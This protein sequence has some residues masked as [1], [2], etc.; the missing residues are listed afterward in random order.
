MSSF[1]TVN[2]TTMNVTG[3]SQVGTMTAAAGVVMTNAS[4]AYSLNAPHS[5]GFE[6]AM[7]A[8]GTK[9][10]N[11][12][13]LATPGVTGIDL[14][15]SQTWL[16]GSIQ[17]TGPETSV[18]M[19]AVHSHK[20]GQVVESFAGKAQYW[21]ADAPTT[22]TMHTGTATTKAATALLY[23]RLLSTGVLQDTPITFS[24]I[25]PIAGSGFSNAYSNIQFCTPMYSFTNVLTLTNGDSINAANV[26]TFANTLTTPVTSV[27]DGAADTFKGVYAGTVAASLVFSP[28]DPLLAGDGKFAFQHMWVVPTTRELY[29]EDIMSERCCLLTGFESRDTATFAPYESYAKAANVV[30]VTA[31]KIGRTDPYIAGA[32]YSNAWT[33]PRFAYNETMLKQDNVQFVNQFFSNIASGIDVYGNA[34]GAKVCNGGKPIYLQLHDHGVLNYNSSGCLGTACL[35]QLYRKAYPNNATVQAMTYYDLLRKEL[36]DPCG[37]SGLTYYF[38]STDTRINNIAS[39][40]KNMSGDASKFTTAVG[41]SAAILA[42]TFGVN[43]YYDTSNAHT[44]LPTTVIPDPVYSVGQFLRTNYLNDAAPPKLYPGNTGLIGTLGDFSAVLQLLTR[45]GL[46]ANGTRLISSRYI[47]ELRIPRAT[48][49]ESSTFSNYFAPPISNRLGLGFATGGPSYQ[50]ITMSYKNNTSSSLNDFYTYSMSAHAAV[51]AGVTFQYDWVNHPKDTS[52]WQGASGILWQSCPETQCTL[53]YA[54]NESL[55]QGFDLTSELEQTWEN[56]YMGANGSSI[57]SISSYSLNA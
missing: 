52:G 40:W 7:D 23:A 54:I 1:G 2:A 48:L 39:V 51:K 53:V 46:L 21:K 15:N 22:S 38:N 5:A 8:I 9:Y 49:G 10:T 35:L 44:G 50:S 55:S 12:T 18:P 27:F 13:S 33:V 37:A 45:N 3:L 6:G 28:V 42:N 14:S 57:S 16:Y 43:Y 29:L 56:E 32:L 34:T 11:Y 19:L 17:T 30:G 20:N 41:Y 36:L 47:A 31:A 26:Y 25:F 4:G 24:S